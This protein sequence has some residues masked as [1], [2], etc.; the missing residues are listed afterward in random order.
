MTVVQ[1]IHEGD[2][3]MDPGYRRKIKARDV[4]PDYNN[5]S[6]FDGNTMDVRRKPEKPF[7][8]MQEILAYILRNQN[9][10]HEKK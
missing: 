7:H 9:S 1:K 10:R 2:A 3:W 6:Y 8:F 5:Q 4:S